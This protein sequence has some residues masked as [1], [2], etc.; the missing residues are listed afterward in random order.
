MGKVTVLCGAV[1]FNAVTVSLFGGTY[2]WICCLVVFMFIGIVSKSS[3]VR[4]FYQSKILEVRIK[5][6]LPL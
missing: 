5:F 2:K 6:H 1:S 4:D 3:W